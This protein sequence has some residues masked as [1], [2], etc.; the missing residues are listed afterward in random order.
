[1]KKWLIPTCMA[2]LLLTGCASESKAM[3][4]PATT[5]PAASASPSPS[6][7]PTGDM[8]GADLTTD[9]PDG[10][11]VPMAS[12]QPEAQGVTSVQDARKAMEQIEDE[13][14]KLSE[15]DDAQVVIAGNDAAIAL[16]FEPEYMAGI[17]QRIRDIVRERLDGVIT[18]V[19]NLAITDDIALLDELEALGDRLNSAT[20]M[21]D[22]QNELNAVINRI[23]VG[24]SP[25]ATDSMSA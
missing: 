22:I 15:V 21:A 1:L 5:P 7:A 17:D 13:L 2:M 24:T 6:T 12:R 23:N 10:L 8:P 3:T 4:D 14:E 19:T 20:D 11:S 9:M 18:G 16:E 25:T